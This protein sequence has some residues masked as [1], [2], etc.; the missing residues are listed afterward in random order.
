MIRD[1]SDWKTAYVAW[2]ISKNASVTLAYANL[3]TVATF[4]NQQGV[5]LSTQISF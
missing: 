4:K 2:F 3:G 1:K 5:Y